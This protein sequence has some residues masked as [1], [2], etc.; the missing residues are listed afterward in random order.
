VKGDVPNRERTAAHIG[1]SNQ[2]PC[3]ASEIGIIN[4]IQLKYYPAFYCLNDNN[5]RRDNKA[6]ASGNI[7][8][9]SESQCLFPL[10]VY[11]RKIAQITEKDKIR[12]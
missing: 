4:Y 6:K 12:E 10:D 3:G 9:N 5:A 1:D 8:K 11:R 7:R 2:K